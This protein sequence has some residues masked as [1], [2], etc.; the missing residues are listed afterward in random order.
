MK[1]RTSVKGSLAKCTYYYHA[2][3]PLF[4]LVLSVRCWVIHNIQRGGWK[5]RKSLSTF[6]VFSEFNGFHAISP[7]YR[8]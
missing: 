2:V 8:R 6:P 4:N 3:S 5:S 1:L 7:K